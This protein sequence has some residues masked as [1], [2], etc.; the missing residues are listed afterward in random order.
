MAEL[1]SGVQT[2]IARMESNPEEFYGE[3]HKWRFIFR[4][5]FREVLT[6]PEK[7]AIHEALKGV[8]R[9]EF[10]VLVV[11]V[12]LEDEMRDQLISG[13]EAFRITS[14]GALGIGNT[15]PLLANN[16]YGEAE[17]ARSTMTLGSF[18]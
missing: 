4:E 17:Q 9:K 15:A 5:N 13:K 16:T 3:A 10:D 8:R 2:L 12:L 6:E 11:K 7:G 14:T 1:S 18:K